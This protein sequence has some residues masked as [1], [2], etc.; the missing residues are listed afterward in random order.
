MS[1]I[2]MYLR[3]TISVIKERQGIIPRYYFSDID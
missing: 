2:L 1:A 3:M